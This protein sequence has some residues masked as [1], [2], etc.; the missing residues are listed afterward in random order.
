[1][2]AIRA[3]NRTQRLVLG[4]FVLAWIGLVATPPANCAPL[5]FAVV[6]GAD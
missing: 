1:V 6:T 5:R 3:T 4:F 2:A